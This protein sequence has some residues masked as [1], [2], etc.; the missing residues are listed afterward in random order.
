MKPYIGDENIWL[1]SRAHHHCGNWVGKIKKAMIFNEALNPEQ[2]F[3]VAAHT[4]PKEDENSHEDDYAEALAE[5]VMN[6]ECIYEPT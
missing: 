2:I 5:V 1:G 3:K 4:Q 6:T